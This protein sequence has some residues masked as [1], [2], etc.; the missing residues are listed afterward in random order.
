MAALSPSSTPFLSFLLTFF[1]CLTS[2]LNLPPPITT[3][4]HMPLQP[5]CCSRLEILPIFCS[6]P[7][8]L[9]FPRQTPTS[10]VVLPLPFCFQC[11]SF[12]DI[13]VHRDFCL[14]SS[15]S[16]FI[17]TQ[18]RKTISPLPHTSHTCPI[19]I[20][21]LWMTVPLVVVVTPLPRLV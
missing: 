12:A 6:G 7:S 14:T 1:F 17:T 8:V 19:S 15:V 3:C 21:T 16:L 18:T 5:I 13:M 11:M 2:Y 10:L 4:L 20:G 9:S